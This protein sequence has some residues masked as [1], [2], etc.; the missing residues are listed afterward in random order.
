MSSP[1]RDNEVYVLGTPV[2]SDPNARMLS[3]DETDDE[4]A[5]ERE[6]KGGKPSTGT[7][8]DRRLR[9]NRDRPPNAPRLPA[10]P[11]GTPPAPKK[12]K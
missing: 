3:V 4:D 11:P 12:E 9:E 5:D 8:A 2:S 7:P 10:R 6:V 1:Y